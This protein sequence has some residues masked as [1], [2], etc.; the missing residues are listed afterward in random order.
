MVFATRDEE[1]ALLRCLEIFARYHLSLSKLESR[2]RPQMPW[3]YL[4]YVDF[5][6]NV[7]EEH[8]RKA[9][10]DLSEHTGFLKVFG[11][12]PARN[13]RESRP[14]QP[15]PK[16]VP[17]AAQPSADDASS[18][19]SDGMPQPVRIGDIVIGK[20]PPKALVYTDT[21]DT[22]LEPL[23]KSSREAGAKLFCLQRAH[24]GQSWPQQ[25][26]L[27][28]ATTLA[29]GLNMPLILDVV[30]PNELTTV[31]KAAHALLVPGD[32]M[33]DA[34]MLSALGSVDR[35]VFLERGL[36]ASVEAWLASAQVI[37]DK[38]NRQ[39]VLCDRGV[40]APSASRQRIL[41]IAAIVH[42]RQHSRLPIVV[43][44]TLAAVEPAELASLTH[45]VLAAGAHG[46][47]IDARPRSGWLEHT[48]QRTEWL[49][50][51]LSNITTS[52]A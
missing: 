6:G 31:A 11:S 20:G 29:A 15:R 19:S 3:E 33:D 8:V 35:P 30:S 28:P 47:M 41:D 49:A 12:Y 17:P 43:D 13:T 23:I 40:H 32:K 37:V 44:P 52:A 4:F 51:I 9:L 2:P 34:A 22:K 7:S 16:T 1:G 46:V 21:D 38:G 27:Q 48:V 45:S 14:A 24:G 25:T 26:A 42:I 39:V 50:S 36:L 10:A 5:L 18:P